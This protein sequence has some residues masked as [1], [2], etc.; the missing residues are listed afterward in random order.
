MIRNFYFS[1]EFK[2]SGVTNE[3]FFFD[4]SKSYTIFDMLQHYLST[5]IMR[6]HLFGDNI[7]YNGRAM[8]MN[9]AN[10]QQIF[11]AESIVG[12]STLLNSTTGLIR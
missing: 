10:S 2:I 11:S 9:H 5:I 1:D 7:L 12:I 6:E 4:V 3:I 8:L